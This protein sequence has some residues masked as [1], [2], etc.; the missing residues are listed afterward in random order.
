M[1]STLRQLARDSDGKAGVFDRPRLVGE[2]ATVVRLKAARSLRGDLERL[3]A[4]ATDWLADIQ[5][6]VGG[7]HLNRPALSTEPESAVARSQFVQIRGLPGS[8]KSVLLRQAAERAL[9]RGPALFLK[10]DRLEGRSWSSFASAIGLSRAPLASLLAEIAATGAGTFFIDGIDRIEKEHQPIILDVLRSVFREPFLR[11]WKVVVSLRDTGIEPLRNWLGEFLNATGIATVEVK[12][13]DDD[14]AEELAGAKPQLR[15]LLFGPP[16]VSAIV[17]RPFFAKVLSQNFT[18]AAS[19]SEVDL[20]EHWWGRG[21][22]DAAG[23]DA[24][25][26]QRAIIELGAFR[27]RNLGDPIAL[28][29]LHDRTTRLVEQMV[30]DGILQHVRH[31]HSIRFLTTSSLSGRSF[32]FSSTAIRHGLMRSRPAASHQGWPAS[33]NS[34]LNRSIAKAWCGPI[35]SRWPRTPKCAP[36]GREPGS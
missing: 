34:S 2:L 1:W 20:I 8:G 12:A 10:S 26:R 4:L 32:T 9:H 25:D 14:E 17:R 16:Q 7:T 11:N 35:F 24:I 28:S 22:Y 15:P 5:N 23:Q 27:A 30:A 31:G 19:E 13:L 36:S 6:D 21:G 33:S 18:S 29:N 3:A